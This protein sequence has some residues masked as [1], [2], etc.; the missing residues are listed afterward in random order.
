MIFKP[1]SRYPADPRAV[2]I[3]ALSIFSGLTALAL[4]SAPASLE[5]VLPWWGVGI[6]A[7]LL[8]VGSAIT[9]IGMAIRTVNGI[10]A[11]QVG[12]VMV[13]VTSIY[14][15]VLVFAEIGFAAVQTIGI[16]LAWGLACLWRWGQLQS[17]INTSAARSKKENANKSKAMH[18]A[19]DTI[20]AQVEQD[21]AD[22][23]IQKAAEGR[24]ELD[25]LEDHKSQ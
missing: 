2:F 20:Y 21:K 22:S 10:I 17:L 15:S 9:L 25:G 3:L 24:D 14:Y 11:E 8:G 6:W 19:E 13:G 16:I 18:E 12:S 5:S 1:A 23:D 7:V 4:E